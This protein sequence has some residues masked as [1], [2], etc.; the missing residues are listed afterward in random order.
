MSNKLE[1]DERY[2]ITDDPNGVI[3]KADAK[4]KPDLN[5]QEY[6]IVDELSDGYMVYI[7][8]PDPS[9]PSLNYFIHKKYILN[10]SNKEED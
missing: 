7:K 8:G 6:R 4:G 1:G 5:G 10:Q 9:Q 2:L 3:H